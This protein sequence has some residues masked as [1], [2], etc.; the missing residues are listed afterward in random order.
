M[1]V[2]FLKINVMLGFMLLFMVSGCG[3]SLLSAEND[4]EEPIV[5]PWVVKI[6]LKPQ[7]DENYLPT[8]D[9][10]IIV[11]L[12][13]HGVTMTQVWPDPKAPREFLSYYNLRGLGTM[14]E[15]SKANCIADFLA[16]GKFEDEV[17]EYGISHTT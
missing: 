13:K 11:L 6:K 14:S 2:S 4:S 3:S 17:F 7:A 12:S 10:E 9:P 8:E 15:E 1:N 5:L 16:T